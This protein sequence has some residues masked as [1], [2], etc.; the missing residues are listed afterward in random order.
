MQLSSFSDFSLRILVF[1]AM[2]PDRSVSTREIAERFDL[3]FDHLA[4]AAQFLSREGFVAASRGRGG[5]IRLAR[6]PSEIS[7]GDVL[8]RTEAGSCVVECLRSNPERPPHCRLIGIC[9][10][11]SSFMK[12]HEAFFA[13]LDGL[14]LAEVLPDPALFKLRLGIFPKIGSANVASGA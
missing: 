6:D 1:L 12:A 11:T 5:G 13:T 14:S 10:L 2:E 7:V 4:K 9:G 3:S 8:R